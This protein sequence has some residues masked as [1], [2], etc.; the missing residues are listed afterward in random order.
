VHLVGLQ[1][2]NGDHLEWQLTVPPKHE[3]QG[4]TILFNLRDT[5][6]PTQALHYVAQYNEIAWLSPI[7]D[8]D[9]WTLD[10]DELRR[11]HPDYFP[12]SWFAGRVRIPPAYRDTFIGSNRRTGIA[13][14][15]DSST[16]KAQAASV[17]GRIPLEEGLAN[18]LGS[19]N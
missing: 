15:F 7:Q 4:V 1:P 14:T 12:M 13:F 19:C 16:P 2:I 17:K 9:E 8:S 18:T 6:D 10:L 11:I 3:D 5:E